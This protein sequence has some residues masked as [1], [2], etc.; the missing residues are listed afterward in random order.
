M[1]ERSR[2][3]PAEAVRPGASR[4]EVAEEPQMNQ[5]LVELDAPVSPT[6]SQ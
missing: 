1:S 5:D 6:D 4:Q 2:R 3:G